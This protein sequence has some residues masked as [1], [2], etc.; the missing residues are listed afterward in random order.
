MIKNNIKWSKIKFMTTHALNI[1]KSYKYPQFFCFY[2][3]NSYN[4]KEKC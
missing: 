4:S 3:R 1:Q 2:K